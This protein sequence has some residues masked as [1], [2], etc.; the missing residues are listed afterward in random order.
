MSAE[1]KVRA[2][3]S[4]IQSKE[5]FDISI[6]IRKPESH[7]EDYDNVIAM[8]EVASEKTIEITM[9]EYL[10]YYENKW[11]WHQS[12]KMAND[13]YATLYNVAGVGNAGNAKPEKHYRFD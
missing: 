12:W 5:D 9:E 10:K 2:L 6:H 8:L 4:R 3:L 13:G 11:E 7:V 1:E